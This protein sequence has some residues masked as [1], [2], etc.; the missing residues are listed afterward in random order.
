MVCPRGLEPLT[1]WFVARRSIQLSYGHPIERLGTVY[2][3]DFHFQGL[4]PAENACISQ[5]QPINCP[6]GWFVHNRAKEHDPDFVR[7][8]VGMGTTG[9]TGRITAAMTC[10]SCG[11]IYD[12][13]ERVNEILRNSGFCVNLTCLEDLTNLPFEA[14]LARKKDG[15]RRSSDR[16]AV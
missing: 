4:L 15:S 11:E 6:Y 8:G 5:A 16:R 10:P 13:A 1:F 3:A 14:V 12:S 7:M 9:D 2:P